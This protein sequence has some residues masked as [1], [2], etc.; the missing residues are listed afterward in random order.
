MTS[1]F[2]SG[3]FIC[4]SLAAITGGATGCGV[5]PQPQ[6]RLD[7][8]FDRTGTLRSDGLFTGMLTNNSVI[9]G[10]EGNT[11]LAQRGIVSVVLS[12]IPAGAN[13]TNVT[14]RLQGSAPEGNP[15]ADFGSMQVDH[16]NVVSSITI[17]NFAGGALNSNIATIS[18]LPSGLNRQ[19]I[20]L[21]VTNQVKEDILAGRPISSFRFQFNNAPSV[22]GTFDQV[23][24]NADQNDLEFRPTA[25]VTIGS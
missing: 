9:A 14:L 6:I 17:T 4:L 21:D 16:V 5:V 11:N 20:E 8:A 18:T 3:L 10:D 2:K 12:P 23:F 19:V 7:T 15:F 13:I 25:A 1:N 22:D 24:F